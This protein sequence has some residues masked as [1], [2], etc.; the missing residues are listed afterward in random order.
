MVEPQNSVVALSSPT[1]N[2]SLSYNLNKDVATKRENHLI[3]AFIVILLSFLFFALAAE[4]TDDLCIM[5]KPFHPKASTVTPNFN[6]SV[7]FDLVLNLSHKQKDLFS[8]MREHHPWFQAN[9]GNCSVK[10]VRFH[11]QWMQMFTEGLVSCKVE[12]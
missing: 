7:D 12:P 4:T 1:S 9:I 10:S 3:M 8:T 5:Q 6:Q 11:I 2:P